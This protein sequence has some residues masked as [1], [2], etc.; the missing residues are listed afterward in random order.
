MKIDPELLSDEARTLAAGFILVDQQ[1]QLLT[2]EQLDLE[3][4][5]GSSIESNQLGLG[6]TAL[7]LDD[8]IEA[9]RN[10][11]TYD[12]PS[13][14]AVSLVFNRDGNL[15]S[16]RDIPVGYDALWSLNTLADSVIPNRRKAKQ[17]RIARKAESLIRTTA[18]SFNQN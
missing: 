18:E 11:S 4:Y 9:P 13:G 8:F 17:A 6:K 5:R 12:G 15:E 2:T 14:R 10:G 3:A 16:I 1:S 7:R